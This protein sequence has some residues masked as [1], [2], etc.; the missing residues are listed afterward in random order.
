MGSAMQADV[1]AT[2]NLHHLLAIPTTRIGAVLIESNPAG[3]QGVS[4][5]WRNQ[6]SSAWM[7]PNGIHRLEQHPMLSK[8][9]FPTLGADSSRHTQTKLTLLQQDS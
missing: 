9:R 3:S 4:A 2:S 6:S 5:S 8:R 1:G 7:P